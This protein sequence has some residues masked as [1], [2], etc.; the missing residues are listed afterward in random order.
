VSPLGPWT[1]L[2]DARGTAPAVAGPVTALAGRHELTA[3]CGGRVA[4]RASSEIAVPGRARLV[5]AGPDCEG[6][7]HWG[8][9]V[10]DLRTGTAERLDALAAADDEPFVPVAAG[11]A[12]GGPA[13][14]AYAW[15]P[16]GRTV[17]VSRRRADA[18][19]VV[20][21]DRSG[22]A[23]GT[24]WTGAGPA[25]DAVWA[26]RDV[27]VVG[28]RRPVVAAPDGTTMAHLD[29][30][31]PPV[32][33]ES[34]DESRLLVVEHGRLSVW[35]MSDWQPVAA[36][37]GSWLDAAIGPA[38]TAVAAL[39]FTGRLHL[40]DGSL[41]PL[42]IVAAPAGAGGVALGADRVVVCGA[43]GAASATLAH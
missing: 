40:L 22:R 8:P 20:L 15:S 17:A 39:D 19:E 6:A 34:D 18:A 2:P 42:E 13:A 30:T 35:D 41:R 33:I 31:T 27:T 14:V 23:I 36:A 28:D 16:D 26:G 3:W 32:R 1:S 5:G 37:D 4:A 43:E 24:V 38:G 21:R 11:R 25:P 29:A 9:W 12:R 10:V 7:V